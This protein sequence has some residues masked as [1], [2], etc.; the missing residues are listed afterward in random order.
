MICKEDKA[1]RTNIFRFEKVRS[2]NRIHFSPKI[3]LYFFPRTYWIYLSLPRP[4]RLI[5]ILQYSPPTP[6]QHPH[7]KNLF[8]S[9]VGKFKKLYF[10]QKKSRQ[11]SILF[12]LQNLTIHQVQIIIEALLHNLILRLKFKISHATKISKMTKIFFAKIKQ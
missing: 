4:I 6:P 9:F 10:W 2:F 8:P 7:Q 11:L 1:P 5:L 12:F 3:S